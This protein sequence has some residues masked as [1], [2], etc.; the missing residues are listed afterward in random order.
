MRAFLKLID[1][2]VWVIIDKCQKRP[3][4]IVEGVEVLKDINS[5]SKDEINECN[6]NS[7]G[8]NVIFMAISFE[9]FKRTSMCEIAKIYKNIRGHS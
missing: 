7:K 6:W 2:Q 9:E 8:I 5:W 1:E 4:S 3:T